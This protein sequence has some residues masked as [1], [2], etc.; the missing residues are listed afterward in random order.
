MTFLAESTKLGILEVIEIYI[1]YNQPVLFSCQ[2]KSGLFY[3]ALSIDET[4]SSEIWLYAPISESRFQ[5]LVQGEV[6]LRDVFTDAE[7]AFVYRV[8]IPCD[9]K[10]N[11]IVDLIDC[12]EIP[13]EDL[14]GE[15]ITIQSEKW[16]D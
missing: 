1:F 8:E 9:S 12:R 3:I 7:D 2:N 6:E 5:R 11:T 13:D 16:D 14:P 10:S 15:G 4:D